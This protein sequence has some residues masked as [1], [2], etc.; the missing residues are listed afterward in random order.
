M[1]GVVNVASVQLSGAMG[2][3]ERESK[4]NSK[5]RSRRQ[6]DELR[7]ETRCGREGGSVNGSSTRRWLK[8][9]ADEGVR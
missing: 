7:Q 8:V 2:R 9:R 4:S 5:S 3:K 6:A 1:A